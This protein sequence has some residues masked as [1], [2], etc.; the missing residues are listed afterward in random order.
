MCV[1]V[2]VFVC[3]CMC[4]CVY[5]CVWVYVWVCVCEYVCEWVCVCVCVCVLWW[6]LAILTCQLD[7]IWNELQSRY[8]GNT[9]D[10]NFEARKKHVFDPAL[11]TGKSS[12]FAPD[13]GWYK[14]LFLINI[15]LKPR[16]WGIL[17]TWNTPSAGGLHKDN[18][19]RRGLFVLHL[20]AL[21]L[22]AQPLEPSSPDS[23]LYRSPDETFS[24]VGL[25]NY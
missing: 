13:L 6:L 18:G 21:I 23:N 1:S 5:M 12:A 15:H 8:E 25:S 10:G 4:V 2:S 3:V 9:C 14:L 11:E 20:L 22:P 24:L 19:R 7:Y 16:S 17:L